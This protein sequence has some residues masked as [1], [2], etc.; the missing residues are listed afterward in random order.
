MMMIKLWFCFLFLNLN[1]VF[2]SVWLTLLSRRGGSF[3]LPC[4]KCNPA[5][6]FTKKIKPAMHPID[7]MTVVASLPCGYNKTHW[8]CHDVCLKLNN[9]RRAIDLASSRGARLACSCMRPPGEFVG[10]SFI[11]FAQSAVKR[12]CIPYKSATW[13]TRFKKKS[14][15]SNTLCKRRWKPYNSWRVV[16][17]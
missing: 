8:C 17:W 10:D 15:F 16:K 5:E 11:M 14:F 4:P 1:S 9:Q 6:T 3:L 2:V 13:H 7:H 12:H